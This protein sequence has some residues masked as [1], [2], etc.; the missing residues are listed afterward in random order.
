MASSWPMRRHDVV[1]SARTSHGTSR[2]RTTD[3]TY[4]E[5]QHAAMGRCAE[6]MEG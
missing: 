1:A 5:E 2:R 6:P 3:A 4:K